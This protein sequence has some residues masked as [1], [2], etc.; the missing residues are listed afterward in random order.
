MTVR[1]SRAMCV[2][3][4][5][6]WATCAGIVMADAAA[7]RTARIG[8]L[9]N[10]ATYHEQFVMDA[11]SRVAVDAARQA[12]VAELR[13]SVNALND[14]VQAK[15][16]EPRIVTVIDAAEKSLLA[17]ERCLLD[18]GIRVAW[19]ERLE[20]L[21]TVLPLITDPARR[22]E[23]TKELN[24]VAAQVKSAPT[25]SD[26]LNSRI[27]G[28]FEKVTLAAN[29]WQPGVST[30]SF[31]RFGREKTDGLLCDTVAFNSIQTDAE[32]QQL[33]RVTTGDHEI[34]TAGCDMTFPEV[35]VTLSIVPSD[36]TTVNAKVAST[37][38]IGK[39]LTLTSA[40]GQQVGSISTT[41]QR[42]ATRFDYRVSGMQC[43]LNKIDAAQTTLHCALADGWRSVS[44][45]SPAKIDLSTMKFPWLIIDAMDPARGQRVGF[46]VQVQNRLASVDVDD[47]GI[48]LHAKDATLGSVWVWRLDGI[49]RRA[50]DDRFTPKPS[51]IAEIQRLASLN[52][53]WPTTCDEFYK[54]DRNAQ[55]V[56]IRNNVGFEIVKDQ[57]A[58]SSS[59]HAAIPP[60]V[61]LAKRYKVP[62]TIAGKVT[63]WSVPTKYGAF[64]TVDNS[65]LEYILPMP[66]MSR[67]GLFAVDGNAEL[68]GLINQ[69]VEIRDGI[70]SSAT[71]WAFRGSASSRQ[72]WPYISAEN[73]K[74]LNAQADAV[75][76]NLQPEHWEKIFK[77]RIEPFSQRRYAYCYPYAWYRDGWV[78]DINW[79]NLLTLYGLDQWAACEGRWDQLKAAWSRVELLQDY[80]IK[81]HDWAWMADSITEFG[82]GAAIDC[83]T[84]VYA[85]QIA[86][87]RMADT[88][89]KKRFADQA[90]Y[91]A[92]KTALTHTTRFAYLEYIQRYNLWHTDSPWIGT[93]NG[94]HEYDAFIHPRHSDPWWG[95]CSLSGF[96]VEPE[97]F[98]AMLAYLGSSPI[99]EWWKMVTAIYPRW[100]DSSFKCRDGAMY[101]GICNYIT[102]P[103][104]YLEFRLGT[105]D[106][107]LTQMIRKAE[108]RDGF[109][110]NPNV[111]GE[112]CSR[113]CPVQFVDW[114]RCTIDTAKYDVKTATAQ[115]SIANPTSM[116]QPIVLTTR[117]KIA[118]VT[119]DGQTITP[120]MRTDRWGTLLVEVACPPGS[121]VLRV[122]YDVSPTTAPSAR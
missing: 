67:H 104:I 113:P 6:M 43:R 45:A 117:Q 32:S 18:E 108:F 50:V 22:S 86:A 46:I 24:D 83:L 105:D 19:S 119:L 37:N 82:E 44:L 72:A 57:W 91:I 2:G 38:W 70:D 79:G 23:V 17:A 21:A 62:V 51:I 103:G 60:V 58:T 36:L 61:M 78:N 94:F 92:A 14:A 107:R 112:I 35:G 111:Y 89:E 76:T 56:T 4:V 110:Q 16:S 87:T 12:S 81:S 121:H 118:A 114:G 25:A 33:G 27:E 10:A 41:L 1:N 106:D 59:E 30:L 122:H 7:E 73:R 9:N 71:D 96:G 84:A 20:Q 69:S 99:R 64:A 53:A 68:I 85:G 55:T 115:A 116:P 97:C 88:L 8:E 34:S 5:M 26:A 100:F 47:K 11:K 93:I 39:T 15:A 48:V 90:L 28:L 49:A 54:I 120:T 31:G 75:A 80:S 29:G 102:T 77:W 3:V 101:G 109:Y 74:R 63:T 42:V 98:D 65:Q 13:K 40:Q 66:P 95:V 52:L